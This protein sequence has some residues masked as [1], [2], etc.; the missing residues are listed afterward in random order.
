MTK[1]LLTREQLELEQTR[2]R[3]Q[4]LPSKKDGKALFWELTARPA[5]MPDGSVKELGFLEPRYL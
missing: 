2:L 3:Q 4:R 1:T 5:I